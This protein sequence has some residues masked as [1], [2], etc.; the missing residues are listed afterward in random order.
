MKIILIFYFKI[1]LPLEGCRVPS[2]SC[3]E[4]SAGKY[5]NLIPLIYSMSCYSMSQQ[6]SLLSG[7]NYI[8]HS[9]NHS[10]I[11]NQSINHFG[12]SCPPTMPR[13]PSNRVAVRF[14]G[15]VRPSGGEGGTGQ[16]KRRI[17]AVGAPVE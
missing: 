14:A 8:N 11:V 3:F 2:H 10:I 7:E 1:A 6:E 4:D 13:N 9:N 16:D 17:K 15:T 5:T 12:E